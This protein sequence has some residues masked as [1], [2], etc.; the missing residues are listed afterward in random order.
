MMQAEA[1]NFKAPEDEIDLAD[2]FGLFWLKKWFILVITF[3][4]FAIGLA[5][6]DRMQPVYRATAT[7]MVKGTK[8]NNPLNSLISGAI[9][10]ND[11]LDTTIKLLKSSQFATEIVGKVQAPLNVHSHAPRFMWDEQ[12]LLQN[13]SVATVAKTQM[14]EISFESNHPEFTAEVANTIAEQFVVYQANL[15]Q[16][17]VERSG[18]WIESKIQEVRDALAQDE[19]ALKAFRDES[20]VVD[21]ASSVTLA[22]QEIAQL[23]KEQRVI[24]SEQEANERLQIK[25]ESAAGDMEIL[26]NVPHIASSSVIRTLMQQRAMHQ[27][28]LSQV[29]LRYL[30]KHPKYQAIV[31]RLEDNRRQ[32][33]DE[34]NAI[35]TNIAAK[36]VELEQQLTLLTMKRN[37]ATAFLENAI[38]NE[39]QYKKLLRSVEANAKLLESLVR[40]QKEAELIAD[41]DPGAGIILVDPAKVPKS[42]VKPKKLL[43]ALLS[44][45][46]GFMLSVVL[47]VILHFLD[48]VHRRFR[49]IA[50][51]HGFKVIGEL[52][53]L[54]RRGKN[55]HL[56]ILSGQG[57]P[58]E[59]YQE[60]VRSIRT[61][62]SLD[63]Q[64][65]GETIIAISS[66]T[67][68][69]GKSSTCLQ[70]AKSFGELEKVL[71]IDADLRDPSIAVALGEERHR[72]GLTNLL[73][74]THQFDECV[75]R[76]EQL[77]VDVLP[78]GLRPM[79]PLLFLSMKRFEKLLT[80]LQKKYDR[81]IM[82]CPPILSVSDALMIS[83]HMGGLTLVV[84]V[85]KTS[86]TKFNHDLELLTQSESQVSGVIL[87]RIKYDKQN[88]YYGEIKRA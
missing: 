58:F 13:L 27:A 54:R 82:E 11:E 64:L 7:V 26:R 17:D 32:I 88:Y 18:N 63:N 50:H 52:P 45:V 38:E 33:E 16:P 14:L 55:K 1:S 15:M 40:K 37:E 4:V 77:N 22:K 81:I 71:I 6:I 67:P 87:N 70:L 65:A 74:Q 2:L 9:P 49:K 79:N 56:P 80:V 35:I 83:K 31:K 24:I 29:K 73:A 41:V 57:K 23:H 36:R 5:V 84:D 44:L 75:F 3:A 78:S 20:G 53:K 10:S 66:L 8:A 68:N 46:L 62:I 39:A 60:C 30:H 19:G 86:L 59:I 12:S 61:K 42:P 34:I 25:I 43:I 48:D 85:Q 69:E 21:I 28:Q 51:H 47:V 76:H 72:P